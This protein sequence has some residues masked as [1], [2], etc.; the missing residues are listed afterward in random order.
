MYLKKGGKKMDNFY[1]DLV[2][3]FFVFLAIFILFFWIF[4]IYKK[5]KKGKI[6]YSYYDYNK[7]LKN[8]EK[9]LENLQEKK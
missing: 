8:A 4:S 3:G 9:K 7:K 1:L 5:I 6:C 2:I